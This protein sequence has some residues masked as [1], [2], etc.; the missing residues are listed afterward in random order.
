M[1][2]NVKVIP[3]AK[4][5]MIKEESGGLKIYLTQPAVEGKA[6]KALLDV[7]AQYYGVKKRQI[8]ITKGLQSRLKTISI[9][10]LILN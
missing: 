7:L 8:V 10:D 5:A 2:I 9:K 1:N 4:R 3:N 6:N